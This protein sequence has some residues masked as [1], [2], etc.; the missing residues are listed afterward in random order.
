M[1]LMKKMAEDIS[2]NLGLDGEITPE[3]I[4]IASLVLNHHRGSESERNALMALGIKRFRDALVDENTKPTTLKM[5]FQN[6]EYRFPSA[7]ILN[8]MGK[9]ACQCCVCGE[10]Y[11]SKDGYVG[12]NCGI[13]YGYCKACFEKEMETLNG[14]N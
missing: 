9:Y 10:I 2:C 12:G 4:E 13:T 3:V 11:D 7:T 1:G 14:D 6:E 8:L 5:I